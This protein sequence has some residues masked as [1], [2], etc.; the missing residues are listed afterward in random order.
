MKNN[1]LIFRPTNTIISSG[2]TITS[3]NHALPYW[4]Q[5]PLVLVIV[6]RGNR[7]KGY[8]VIRQWYAI[9][10]AADNGEKEIQS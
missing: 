10:E 9:K 7:K 5:K 6:D 3:E 8:L 1:F 2:A 4:I